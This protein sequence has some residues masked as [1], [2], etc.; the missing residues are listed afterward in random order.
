MVDQQVEKRLQEYIAAEKRRCRVK[1]LDE[2]STL[3]DSILRANPVFISLDSLQR[4]PVPLRPPNP[5][6][7]RKTDTIRIE[8]II[9]VKPKEG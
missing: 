9:Q 7:E 1:I 6:F 3:A 5:E 2:A 8:P 4:P